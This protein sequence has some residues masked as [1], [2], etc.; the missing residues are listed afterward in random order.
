MKNKILLT[1][2]LGMFLF[3]LT[4]VYALDSMGTFRQNEAV[5]FRQVCDDATYITITSISYP[6]SNIAISNISMTNSGYG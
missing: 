6:D 4:S 1:I 3:S 2:I 5:D